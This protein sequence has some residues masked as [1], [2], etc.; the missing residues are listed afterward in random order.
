M[1]QEGLHCLKIFLELKPV[2][3]TIAADCSDLTAI[4]GISRRGEQVAELVFISELCYIERLGTMI[5]T[6]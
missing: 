1:V 6:V 4:A 3:P 2:A 5:N